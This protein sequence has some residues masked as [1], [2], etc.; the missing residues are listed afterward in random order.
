M[1]ENHSYNT[2][3][4]GS[5]DWNVP[6]N[7]NFENLDT[8]V[9]VR[10]E[11]E[12]RADYAPKNG[13]KF[14][15]TD[16]GAVYVGDGS[17]WTEVPTRVPRSTTD[18]AD[19]AVGQLWYRADED[20]LKVETERG[21]QEIRLA[22]QEDEEDSS[23]SD[24]TDAGSSPD[25]FLQ[26]DGSDPLDHYSDYIGGQDFTMDE[27]QSVSGGQS[28]HGWIHEG[29]SWGGNV[30]YDLGSEGHPSNVD[31]MHQRV[32]FYLGEGFSMGSDENC[33]IFNA[34][35]S[36]GSNN[37]GGGQPTGSDGWS[38]RLYLTERGSRSDGTWNLLS[39]TYHMDQG[40]EWGTLTTIDGAG[41]TAGE[42]HQI[43]TY[44]R[45]NSYSGGSASSDGVVRYWL[46]DDLVHERTDLR[47]TTSDD[48]RIQWGGPVLHYGGGYDAPSDVLVWYDDHQIWVDSAGPQ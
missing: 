36:D 41:L 24:G 46:N 19:A 48:N 4:Q 29:R 31:E 18:P 33:R 11:A 2:P 3:D 16:T 17:E 1:T 42:W 23:G 8:D 27:R 39:Y 26:M 32:W 21:P 47:F 12:N 45:V 14:F 25:V 34:A 5:T 10:D 30:V 40:G 7:R 20:T 28:L 22:T 13:A 9:E 15:A 44:V 43:D 38:E 6:L 35:L 37:S